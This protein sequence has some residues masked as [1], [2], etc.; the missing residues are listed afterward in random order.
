MKFNEMT[1]NYGLSEEKIKAFCK[2][3]SIPRLIFLD[4]VG[5][6]NTLAKE[7]AECEEIPDEGIIIAA[8]RQ[9]AGRGRLGRSFLSDGRGLYFSYLFKPRLSPADN[10]KITPFA[11]VAMARAIDSVCGTAV[12][13]KWVNDLYLGGKKLAGILTE[14]GF[15]NDGN[16]KYAIVGIGVNINHRELPEELLEIATD[17]EK[18]TGRS[19]D[20]NLILAG[21]IDEFRPDNIFEVAAAQEYRKRSVI[22]GKRVR[23][24]SSGVSYDAIATEITDNGELLVKTDTGDVKKLFTGEVS[25]RFTK[26]SD[27]ER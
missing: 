13:I 15:D 16:L 11:A 17:L 18:E 3:G 5:S 4:E 27:S 22:L 12:G 6:T 9:T 1:K 8:E 20:K 7:I 19:F 25:I 10:L 26:G 14:G 23:V 2:S 24:E 21:F